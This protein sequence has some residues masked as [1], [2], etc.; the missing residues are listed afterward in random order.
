[1]GAS[2]PVLCKVMENMTLYIIMIMHA[3]YILWLGDIGNKIFRYIHMHVVHGCML[4]PLHS[5]YCE[6]VQCF[7]TPVCISGYQSFARVYIACAS[8][9][10]SCVHFQTLYLVWSILI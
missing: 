3:L 5:S 10:Y 9:N 6:Q 1:M 2:R 4:I 7:H 8:H